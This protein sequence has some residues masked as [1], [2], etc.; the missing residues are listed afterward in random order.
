[1]RSLFELKAAELISCGLPQ[2]QAEAFIAAIGEL[3]QTITPS[4]AWQWLTGNLLRPEHP[5]AV[6]EHLHGMIFADWDSDNG[7]APAWFPEDPE[8]SNIAWLMRKVGKENYRDLHAWSVSQ[9]QEFWATMVE[10]LDVQF[11]QTFLQSLRPGRRPRVPAVARRVEA[12]RRGQLFSSV[13]RF[14]CGH[15]R[16]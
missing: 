10:R 8:S 11:R 9:P 13:Q 14:G 15:L 16:L 6:H 12:E 7:P 3:D 1:M 2:D 5:L 4:Q